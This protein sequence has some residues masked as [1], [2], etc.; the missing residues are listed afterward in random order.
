VH[1]HWIGNEMISISEIKKI[2]KK[3]VWTLHD[4]WVFSGAE[5]V[6]LQGRYRFSHEKKNKIDRSTEIIDIDDWTWRR[7]YN[8][9]RNVNFNFVTPSKWLA[10]CLSESSLFF[11]QKAAVIPNCLDIDIFKPIK[12]NSSQETENYSSRKKMILFGAVRGKD[13]ALKGFSLLKKALVD[14]S[15]DD[16]GKNI[17]CIVFGG[18]KSDTLEMINGIDVRDVGRINDD[19]KLA[20]LYSSADVFVAPSLLEAFGQTA[21]EAH[22][23]GTPVVAFNNSGL[24][25]IIEHKKTGYL[26]EAFNPEDL[27]AGIAWVLADEERLIELGKQARKKAELAY[28]YKTVGQQ[29]KELYKKILSS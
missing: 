29:Y 4:M 6:D 22:A 9:W 8:N 21:S 20:A 2:K 28:N 27:A 1:L 26:A 24:T 10:K 13:D 5:H 17:E 25:D 19:N 12:N 14:I 15:S 23:C 3:I 11:G 18:D 7:K 16:L